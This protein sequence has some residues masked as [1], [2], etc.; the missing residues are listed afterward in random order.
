MCFSSNQDS[1][2]KSH[3]LDRQ[4]FGGISTG[5]LLFWGADGPESEHV[6][7]GG[8][9]LPLWKRL[10]FVNWD[11]DNPNWMGK[12]KKIKDV[13]NH[14]PGNHSFKDEH[15]EHRYQ[16]CCYQQLPATFKRHWPCR[17]GFHAC[18]QPS[19]KMVMAWSWNGTARRAGKYDWGIRSNG[20]WKLYMIYDIW[21]MVYIYIY[22]CVY[23]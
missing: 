14:Q 20:W 6:L 2:S 18:W 21:Y 17:N 8:G 9:N 7:V 22:T 16:P 19:R 15:H 23:L 4:S 1:S 5:F 13:R 11:D 12:S 3:G 10:E